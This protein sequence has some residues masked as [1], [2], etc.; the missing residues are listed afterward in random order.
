[1]QVIKRVSI[2]AAESALSVLI[3]GSTCV[4]PTNGMHAKRDVEQTNLIKYPTMLPRSAYHPH[5]L[6][7]TWYR[8]RVK[9]RSHLLWVPI[10]LIDVGID[11]CPKFTKF[12]AP[13]QWAAITKDNSIGETADEWICNVNFQ[14]AS[15][16]KRESYQLTII[17]WKGDWLFNEVN[18]KM[19]PTS[20]D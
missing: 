2:V 3:P 14:E 11:S 9:G 6:E 12:A 16:E 19:P 15:L 17:K 10:C 13:D 8:K 7:P 20:P 5:Q 4:P 1:M 18:K